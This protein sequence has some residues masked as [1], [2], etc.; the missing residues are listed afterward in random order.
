[1]KDNLAD[2]QLLPPLPAKEEKLLQ[3][4]SKLTFGKAILSILSPSVSIVSVER[5]LNL[6]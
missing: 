2:T 3:Q 1:M 4:N 5:K 6:C